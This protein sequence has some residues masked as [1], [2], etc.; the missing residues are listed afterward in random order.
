M[1]PTL[2]MLKASWR[3]SL[4]AILL[5]ATLLILIF[6]RT[7]SAQEKSPVATPPPLTQDPVAGVDQSKTPG[8]PDQSPIDA[9]ATADGSGGNR[10]TTPEK[11]GSNWL[12]TLTIRNRTGWRTVQPRRVQMSRSYVEAKGLYRID[13]NWSL[14]LEGRAH[15]DPVG[16]LGYPARL[17]LDPRQALVDGRVGRIDLKLGLQQVVWG[18]ADGL[19]VLDVV[20]PLDYREFILEDFLDSRRP[21]W[22]A[23]ADIPVGPGSLQLLWVPYFAP[24]RL[25][26]SGNEF[27]L[28][29]TPVL[30]SSMSESSMSG[31]SVMIGQ[32]GDRPLSVLVNPAHRPGYRAGSSQAGARYQQTVGRWDL[33]ANYFHGWED[34]PTNYAGGL[35]TTPD[36]PPA[37]VFNPRYD[38]KEVVGG[39]ATTS[40]GSLVLRVEAGLNRRKPLAVLPARSQSGFTTASQFS[41]V[42]GLDYSFRPWLWISGQYFLQSAPFAP[43]PLVL[44]RHN[45]LASL[46]LRANFRRETLRPELFILTGLREKQY[47]F[48]PRLTRTLGDHWSLGLGLDL[49]GGNRQN[50]FGYFDQR[51]RLVI[52]LKWMR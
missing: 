43:G 46:Y 51:D 25:P 2:P 7:I 26:V 24:G 49:L 50:P 8:P 11:P 3:N 9:T 1:L 27:G 39:T 19:R 44:P 13:D 31:S 48:R 29:L 21:L 10:E 37:A 35:T 30:E 6:Q 15:Y 23:R 20:N 47:L 42:V 22:M 45:H 14:T 40:F 38:R 34:L 5:I 33:T 41:S 52:E 16:R 4:I 12:W 36:R 18:Q 32:P 17:W 28:G